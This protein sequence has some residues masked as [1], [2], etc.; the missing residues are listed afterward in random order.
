MD[1]LRKMAP[2]DAHVLLDE[3]EHRW[4]Y[5]KA[6][7]ALYGITFE[8][9]V[10][11]SFMLFAGAEAFGQE[12]STTKVGQARRSL[13]PRLAVYEESEI[14]GV[15]ITPG[16]LVLRVV[17]YGHSSSMVTEG[18]LQN[19]AKT[20]GALLER[21]HNKSG[22]RRP[23]TSENYA[24]DAIVEAIGAFARGRATA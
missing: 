17:L 14:R 6:P 13:A 22:A 1:A 4:E 10:H 7:A 23:V 24:G 8:V 9:C 5:P 16:S 20:E 12:A 21:V 15:S 11:Q 19:V 2:A 18:E 3:L